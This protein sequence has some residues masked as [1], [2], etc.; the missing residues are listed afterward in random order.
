MLSYDRRKLFRPTSRRKAAQAIPTFVA[1][2][3]PGFGTGNVTP[4]LPAGIETDD[5]LLLFAAT[6]NQA[7]ALP[8]GWAEVA[9]SPQGSGAG[10]ASTSTR[11]TAFW[12]RVAG[13]E[14]APTLVDVWDNIIAAIFAFRGCIPT[15][16]PWDV[17]AGDVGVSSTS[18]SVPGDATTVNNC[19]VVAACSQTTDTTTPQFS[20]WA[21]P[22]LANVAEL[23]D[24]GT[25][26]GNGGGFGVASG[27][28]VAAGAYG[29]TTATLATA[30]A[31]GRM[32]IALKPA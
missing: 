19:L 23:I 9:D 12:L 8:A 5:I 16:D 26:A 32:S 20:G 1:A 13:G 15:G 14:V 28:K 24:A 10:G 17:T 11:I 30:S 18:V 3:T 31:Q 21:N 25:D 27:E 2:G 4:G 22:D 29:A 7:I 6:P